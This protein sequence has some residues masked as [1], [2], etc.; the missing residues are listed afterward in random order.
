MYSEICKGQ[1]E[2]LP[3]YSSVQL[4]LFFFL[5]TTPLLEPLTSLSNDFKALICK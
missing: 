3:Y 5:K 4:V 1:N 2:N